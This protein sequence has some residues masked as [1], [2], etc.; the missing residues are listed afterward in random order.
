MRAEI[1]RPSG[2]SDSLDWRPASPTRPSLTIVDVEARALA[3]R[4]PAA[5]RALYN[6]ANRREEAAELGRVERSR[7]AAGVDLC[8]P[9]RLRRVDVADT[10]DDTLIEQRD[11][12]RNPTAR[13]HRSQTRCGER[14]VVRLWSEVERQLHVRRVDIDGRER[15]RIFQHDTRAIRE[16]EDGARKSRQRLGDP[17]NDPIT[18]HSEMNVHDAAIV[19]THELMLPAALDGAYVST[20]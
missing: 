9:E 10:G 19:E 6:G 18:I 17:A 16:A 2:L 12:Y 13:E 14:R 11:F 4:I 20:F 7:A 8:A 5:S 3:A 15:A 1:G